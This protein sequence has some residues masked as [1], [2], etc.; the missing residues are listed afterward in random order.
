MMQSI[1]LFL[2]INKDNNRCSN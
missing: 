1:L 2:F